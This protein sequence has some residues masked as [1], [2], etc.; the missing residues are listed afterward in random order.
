MDPLPE[1]IRSELSNAPLVSVSVEVAVEL[2]PF[3]VVVTSVL[4][5]KPVP[6]T[7]IVPLPP[8]TSIDA[9][10]GVLLEVDVLAFD[11]GV[12][13][14]VV[15]LDEAVDVEFTDAVVV[16]TALV[17]LFTMVGESIV[18]FSVYTAKN[19][20]PPCSIRPLPLKTIEPESPKLP[21]FV[22]TETA[23]VLLSTLIV[24]GAL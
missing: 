22:I 8:V 18:A 21:A 6:L 4:G 14:D 17:K 9:V 11:V 5:V 3:M 15:V 19:G 16:T 23:Y 24:I 7:V 10:E 12:L 2:S 1:S 13:A 20:L